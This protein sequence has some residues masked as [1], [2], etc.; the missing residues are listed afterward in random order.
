V[1]LPQAR[2]RLRPHTTS[3]R[4]PLALLIATAALSVGFGS[5]DE[6]QPAPVSSPPPGHAGVLRDPVVGPLD[7]DGSRVV[8][9]YAP[10]SIEALPLHDVAPDADLGWPST[11]SPLTVVTK[12]ILKR[13][14]TLSA[15]L[16]D[17]GI[18]SATIHLISQQMRGVFDFRYARPGHRYRLGQDP[19]GMLLDFR[20]STSAEKSY[21]LFWDGTRYT[22]REDHAALRT[23]LAKVSG[24]VDTS[25]YDAIQALGEHTALAGAFADIFAWDIDFSRSVRPGDDFQILYERLYRTDDD[26]EEI[27]VRPGRILAARYRG[28]AGSHSAIYFEGGGG[29][30]GYYRP[31]GT[32]IERAFLVAPLEFR[33]ISSSFS[34]ARRHPI[35]GVVRPHRGID[36]AAA[37]GTPVWSVADGKVIYR[38]WAGASGNLVKIQHR[39]GYVS[40]YAHLSRFESGLKLGDTVRQKQVVGYVGQTGLATGP[41]VCFRVQKNG[42]Y[43]NPLDIVSPP[44]QGIAD[45]E[46]SIFKARRDVLL[47]DLG[48]AT[49]VAADEAL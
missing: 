33:R 8:A 12:G 15:A 40:Y 30:A 11:A 46:W 49:L 22:V 48:S 13:G 6:K 32:A 23:Q 39:S 17:H 9:E 47:S 18:S 26:G 10:V 36:Y 27:Y 20:Y 38:G 43:V 34:K 35:L 1:P 24:V 31:D 7:A 3:A 45:S 41:H 5:S 4:L 2:G 14:Q 29:Q 16:R 44:A 28:A 37:P 19:E 42:R 21:Y 25:L